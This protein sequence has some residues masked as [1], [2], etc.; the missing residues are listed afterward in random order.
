MSR[1]VEKWT[2]LS[3]NFIDG[4]IQGKLLFLVPK[5]MIISGVFMEQLLLL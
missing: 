2:S 5:N 4:L 3:A 1:N